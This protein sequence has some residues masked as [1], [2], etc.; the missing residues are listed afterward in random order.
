MTCVAPLKVPPPPS[1]STETAVALEQGEP[2]THA[3]VHRQVVRDL[4]PLLFDDTVHDRELEARL[5]ETI[6]GAFEAAGIPVGGELCAKVAA[7]S[8]TG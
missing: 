8:S 6:T 1:C 2:E 3:A 4:G 7:D 5:L